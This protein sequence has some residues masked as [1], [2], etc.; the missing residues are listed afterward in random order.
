M[1]FPDDYTLVPYRGRPAGLCPDGPRYMALG[2][3]I[4]VPVLRWI[5]KRI[6]AVDA[7]PATALLQPEDVAK[8]LSDSELIDRCVQGFRKLKEAAPYL[9]EARDRFSQPGRRVP[10]P[11]NPTWTEWVE[12]NLGVTVRRVQQLLSEAAEPGE[13]VSR[14]S[15]RPL[16]LRIGDWR[17]L[18]KV[19]ESR[20]A[21]VFG[22]LED[23]KELAGAI[24][25]FAQGIADRFGEQEGRLLVSVSVKKTRSPRSS[26]LLSRGASASG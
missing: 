8:T 23:E 10:V 17:R 4:A 13:I 5:G 11:G 16:K 6:A 12:V 19:S 2:N 7:L 1:G 25:G 3:S 14:G 20:L 24:R 21:K 15:K 22:P 18:L 9:R 26:H